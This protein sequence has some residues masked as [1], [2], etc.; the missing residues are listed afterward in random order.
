MEIAGEASTASEA[1]EMLKRTKADVVLLDA[2]TP[3]SPGAKTIRQMRAINPDTKILILSMDDDEPIV[4]S[5]L[6]A[7][8]NGHVGKDEAAF[9]LKLMINR[10]CGW[11]VRTA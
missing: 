2:T 8:A 4:A 6:N 1:I 9:H 11:N 10:A 5:C 3:D 7:G